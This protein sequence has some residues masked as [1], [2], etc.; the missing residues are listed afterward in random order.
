MLN[1]VCESSPLLSIEEHLTCS[2]F[3]SWSKRQLYYF[4]ITLAIG[5][6]YA[7]NLTFLGNNNS[8]DLDK[9]WL[10]SQKAIAKKGKEPPTGLWHRQLVDFCEF[11]CRQ[12]RLCAKASITLSKYISLIC[13]NCYCTTSFTVKPRLEAHPCLLPLEVKKKNFLIHIHQHQRLSLGNLVNI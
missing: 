12:G 2:M 5:Y 6:Y 1:N 10:E 7:V 3:F 4:V 9:F 13:M 11:K 8:F